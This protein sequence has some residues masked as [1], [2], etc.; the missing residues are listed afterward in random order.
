MAASTLVPQPTDRFVFLDKM[1]YSLVI[2]VVVLHAAC[3]YARIIPWWSV[4]DPVQSP[5]FDLLI[6]VLDIFLMPVLFFIAGYFAL[7][8]LARRGN[9]GFVNAKLKRLG[10]PFVLVGLFF[11]PVI[12]FIGYRSRTPDPQGFFRFWWMQMETVLDWH[13]VSYATQEIALQHA[14]DFSPWH[15]WF[16]SLLLVFFLLT[17]LFHRFLPG[18]FQCGVT[19]AADGSRSVLP[20]L[21]VAASAGALGFCLVNR[22]YPDWAW[23]KIG[24]L[25]L[26]QPTR[27]PIYLSLF[28]LGIHA[29]RREWFRDGTFPGSTWLWLTGV[30]VSSATLLAALGAMELGPA[31]TPWLNASVHGALRSVA[32]LAFLGLFITAGLRY[33]NRPSAAWRHLHPI[34]YDIYLIHLPLVV[35]LQLALLSVAV[36]IYLKFIVT[37]LAAV[38]LCWLLGRHVIEPHPVP[39]G[40][41]LFTGF[42]LGC[43]LIVG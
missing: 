19:S 10:I 28:I 31:P 8:S 35:L 13:W 36:S 34:S 14:N 39:A 6:I 11:V 4:R 1:R 15:L 20:A 18:W 42:A 23:G 30:I 37:G 41:L 25:I 22:V 40:G 3:A 27:L 9:R 43:L 38:A 7:S 33:G 29:A 12:T 16:I 5:V 21:A 24:G 17:A 2:G 32:C 26:I